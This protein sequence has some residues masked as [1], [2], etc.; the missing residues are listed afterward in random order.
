M[1][2]DWILTKQ[3][4]TDKVYRLLA[5][6]ADEI[7]EVILMKGPFVV[8]IPESVPKISKG[9]NYLQFPWVM[10]DYPRLFGQEDICAV[11]TMFWWGN[12]FSITLHLS[13]KYRS[14]INKAVVL[15]H[16]GSSSGLH[17][18]VNNDQWQHHFGEGNYKPC[19]TCTETQLTE[20]LQKENFIKLALRYDIN[21]W[22]D[23]PGLLTGGYK[24]ISTLL[25]S[26][27]GGETIL[28]PGIPTTGSGL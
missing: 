21:H 11:R 6:C 14:L 9:E 24:L 8:E 4:I 23:L 22:N 20:L 7:R 19:S 12:F 3:A 5:A 25:V 17:I 15:K 18:C 13:G 2:V 28:S 26:C 1:N 10:L 27:R 16:A